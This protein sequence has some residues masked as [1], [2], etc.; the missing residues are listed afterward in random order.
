MDDK[1]KLGKVDFRGDVL[2]FGILDYDRKTHMY[3]I[4][5]SGTGKT[6]FL[7][8]L[9][10]SDILKGYGVCFIDPHGEICED[11]LKHIPEERVKDVVYFNPFDIEYPI[12]FNIMESVDFDKRYNVTGNLIAVFKKIWPDVWS[13]RMLEIL[14]NTI[15]AL[16][17]TPDA[18]LFHIPKF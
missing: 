4:G 9:C 1:T 15:L 6:T 18:T 16:L 3:I 7:E 12:S 5:K 2:D 10:M 14:T 8:N 11:L 13:G 17:E